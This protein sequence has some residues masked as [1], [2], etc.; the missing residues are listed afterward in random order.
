MKKHVY[1]ICISILVLVFGLGIIYLITDTFRAHDIGSI[2]LR[3]VDEDD[4]VVFEG[5]I[6][7]QKNDTFFDI[8]NRTFEITC[9][10]A[11]YQKDDSCQFSFYIGNAEQKVILGIKGND[12]EIDS[13]WRQTFIALYVF[14]DGTYVLAEKGFNQLTFINQGKYMIKVDRVQ[15]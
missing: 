3:I 4:V 5:D 1:K 12:F 10:N 11:F 15:S 9:A 6:D 2:T 8:L 7:Y 14:E 13:D